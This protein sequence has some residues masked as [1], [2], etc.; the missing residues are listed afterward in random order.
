MA[1]KGKSKNSGDPLA[2][3]FDFLYKEAKKKKPKIKPP[4]YNNISNSNI[5]AKQ[6]A[7][8]M[9]KPGIY[10]SENALGAINNA[11]DQK[12]FE[13]YVGKPNKKDPDTSGR[14]RVRTSDLG[15]LF[16]NPKK[17]ID[18]VFD[19][20]KATRKWNY[21][22]ALGKGIDGAMALAWASKNG[23]T[24][25]NA[26]NL[27][28]AAGGQVTLDMQNEAFKK[29]AQNI[30]INKLIAK[31]QI[32]S[33]ALELLDNAKTGD[34]SEGNLYKIFSKGFSDADARSLA[35][36]VAKD[37]TNEVTKIKSSAGGDG[38]VYKDA[39]L[40]ANKYREIS[41]ENLLK[42]ARLID[43]NTGATPQEVSELRKRREELLKAASLMSVLQKTQDAGMTK[44]ELA[45]QN[46]GIFENAKKEIG[47]V[48]KIIND[49]GGTGSLTPVEKSLINDM[50]TQLKKLEKNAID[51]EKNAKRFGNRVFNS[52]GRDTRSNKLYIRSM[53]DEIELLEK[54]YN[55]ELSI[56]QRTGGES[57]KVSEIDDK[58]RLLKLQKQQINGMGRIGWAHRFEALKGS[59]DSINANIIKGGLA[60]N[61]LLGGRGFYGTGDMFDPSV[62]GELAFNKSMFTWKT[63]EKGNKYKE[64]NKK[65]F[66]APNP[67]IKSWYGN[68]AY[69]YYLNPG[70]IFG[71]LTNGELFAFLQYRNRLEFLSRFKDGGMIDKMKKDGTYALIKEFFD[72]K[73]EL[74]AGDLSKMVLSNPEKLE[75]L[76]SKI[77]KS[78][79]AFASQA[80]MLGRFEK[81]LAG[82]TKL[83]ST[84]ERFFGVISDKINPMNNAIIKKWATTLLNRIIGDSVA[85]E[86]FLAKSI[87]FR[88]LVQA[89]VSKLLTAIGMSVGGPIGGA[90]TAIASAVLVELGM[91]VGKFMIEIFFLAA[92]GFVA[93]LLVFLFG[94]VGLFNPTTKV[95]NTFAHVTPGSAKQCVDYNPDAGLFPTPPDNPGGG[96]YPPIDSDCPLG[97]SPIICTQGNGAG[98]SSYH[99]STKAIDIGTRVVPAGKAVWYAP[100]NGKITKYVAVNNCPGT[101][102]DYG[103]H[104]EFQDSDG[105]VYVLLHVKALAPVGPVQKGRAVALAQDGL[106]PSGDYSVTCWTGPHFHLHVKSKG[107]YQDSVSWY[108]DK[109]K[110]AMSPC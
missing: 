82:A 42:R 93:I 47:T 33:K 58:L 32:A 40:Q 61:L 62:N 45:A 63:D 36:E 28:Y 90:L 77:A 96:D 70:T 4:K 94:F 49:I 110:C 9:S 69:L 107:T 5:I 26:M 91:K 76:L 56:L 101:G 41:L 103:G 80:A 14:L 19:A 95:N 83:F 73:G 79:G 92:M 43:P 105:N 85:V 35:A 81:V 11:L 84:P 2:S 104:L 7:E 25:K 65:G 106:D 66:I 31:P 88:Q 38:A 22:V 30:A 89:G 87:G 39:N 13:S 15:K 57:S 44:I 109:L 23:V 59:W 34:F 52:Y 37:H 64:F 60:S 20:E 21:F 1:K 24:G 6:M 8:L 10:L 50:Q 17:Y 46:K 97:F 86:Q 100:T 51:S 29:I 74:K 68:F 55:A 18:G 78:K 71:S 48:Q 99:Q 27:A 108:R 72:D 53:L 102:L 54:R 67:E 16:S 98:T 3:V 75:E 12:I